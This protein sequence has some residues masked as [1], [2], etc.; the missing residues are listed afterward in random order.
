MD[1]PRPIA[2]NMDLF[3]ELVVFAQ[4]Q[5]HII[6]SI[7]RTKLCPHV[8]DTLSKLFY[9]LTVFVNRIIWSDNCMTNVFRNGLPIKLNFI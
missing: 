8:Q 6:G 4:I 1:G 2:Q 5:T 9:H 7:I 3:K